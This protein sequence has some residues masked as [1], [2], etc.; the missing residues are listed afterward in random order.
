MTLFGDILNILISNPFQMAD[1]MK[2]ANSFTP[3]IIFKEIPPQ[4][5]NSHDKITVNVTNVL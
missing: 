1:D 3:G 4:T 2:Y 5:I